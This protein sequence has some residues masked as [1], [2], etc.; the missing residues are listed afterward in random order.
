MLIIG[1]NFAEAHP[2][3]FQWAM[4]ARTAGTKIIHVDPRFSRTSASADQFVPIR[5][6][7]DI[8]FIGGLINY[9][10]TNERWFTEFVDAYTNAGHVVAEGIE[11]PDELDGLFSGWVTDEGR[12]DTATWQFER[13]ESGEAVTDPTFTHPRCVMSL[14]RRHYARYTPEMV[15]DICGIDPAAFDR[16]ADT[17]TAASG[18]DR[19]GMVCYAVGLTM[20]SKGVQNIRSLGV[21][22]LL[23]GN[24]GRP[25]GG[26]LALRGHANVQGATDLPVL[27]DLWPGYLPKPTADDVDLAGYLERVAKPTGWWANTPAYVVSLLKA[28][29][30]DA[31]T[32]ENDYCFDRMPR[33]TGDHSYMVT[34]AAMADGAVE[35]MMVAGENVSVSSVHG[36]LQRSGFRKLRWMVVRDLTMIE[37]AE[38]WKRGE[39]YAKDRGEDRIDPADVDTEVFLFPAAAH[40][41]KEGSFTN[42]QRILQ[43]KDQAVLPPGDARSELWFTHHLMARLRD[44]YAD[45]TDLKDQPIL[46]G[47]WDYEVEG[48][49]DE[50][51]ANDVLA[52]IGGFGPDGPLS[53]FGEL[54]DDGTTSA[55]AWTHVGVTASGDNHARHR[56]GTPGEKGAALDWGWAW[57][58]N[59]R[60]LYNRASADP[61]GRPWSEDKALIWWDETGGPDGGGAWVGHDTPDFPVDRA[62]SYRPE[63]GDTGTDAIAGDQPFLMQTDGL[64][65][66]WVADGLRDGP[67]PTH[68]E[69]LEGVAPNRL[70]RQ[71]NTP[72]RTQ[73]D[74][75]DNPYHRAYD[76]PRF[77]F[78]LTTYRLTE[79]FGSGSMANRNLS[80]LGELQP[81][82]FCEISPQLAELRGIENGG[83]VTMKS[84]R[85]EVE[86]R[87]LV[88]RRLVPLQV[89]GRTVHTVGLPYQWGRTGQIGGAAPN[90]LQ[91]ISGE[92]NVTIEEC[93]AITIDLVPG[94][95]ARNLR[96]GTD[97]PLQPEPDGDAPARDL[98]GITRPAGR[99]GVTMAADQQGGEPDSQ[100]P[101]PNA[102][103]AESEP[104]ATS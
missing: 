10:L 63:P 35:G 14:L 37:T 90:E 30:G 78:V 32:A 48:A 11:L 45:S 104:G 36:S 62:P 31:A 68:Y 69:P 50:P 81:E 84:L 5:P 54:R 66:L 82:L 92:A 74:R 16:A 3:G 85:A 49:L 43:W 60:N 76:D 18:R 93:K 95:V 44:I 13:D 34:Q 47:T 102:D 83:W 51:S 67:L 57:P 94:R 22:Q 39:E 64:G 8:A 27:Y 42:T 40:V 15:S 88:T 70:Y 17:F 9:V 20:H 53:S 100:A 12:Y 79:T 26:I 6:G 80:W 29:F 25:G 77:P 89:A 86:M 38:F 65:A 19:T 23:L 73:W 59:R 21:L 101:T 99:H 98:P 46:D 4:E 97:G 96:A 24:I 61:E 1:S 91:K 72:A 28:W 2:V 41:E 75:D 52:E 55:G 56:D 71:Q 58:A 7:T 33:L 87:V 103:D